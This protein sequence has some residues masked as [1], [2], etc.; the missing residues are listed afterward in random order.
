MQNSESLSGF[1]QFL[2]SMQAMSEQQQSIN[3]STMQLSQLG[4]SDQQSLLN[5]LL[6]QQQQL[7]QQLEEMLDNGSGDNTGSLDKISE[8]MDEVIQDLLNNNVNPETIERQ[9]EILSRMLD[10]QK[11]MEKKDFSKKRESKT[12]TQ[13]YINLGPDGLP[14]N[15]GEKDLLLINA[16][17]KAMEEGYSEEYNQYIRKYFLKLQQLEK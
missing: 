16:M 3:Q 10:S 14:T 8:D 2:E 1:E 12:N 9:Q 4:L 7:K 17:E 15:L 13:D 5:E 11:S 6:S